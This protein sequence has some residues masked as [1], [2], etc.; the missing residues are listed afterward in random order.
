[1]KYW[2]LEI[3]GVIY[4]EEDNKQNNVD[5]VYILA[6]VQSCELQLKMRPYNR[7]GMKINK[8]WPL[9]SID[10]KMTN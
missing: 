8:L 3:L 10:Q 1:M 5:L 7:N 4:S 9:M 6:S 2:S